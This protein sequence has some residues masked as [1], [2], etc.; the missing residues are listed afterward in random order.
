VGDHKGFAVVVRGY[1]VGEVD[2]IMERIHQATASTDGILRAAV[3]AELTKAELS[4]RLRGY[5][6]V[7]VDDYLRRAVD[8]LA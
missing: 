2:A 5:D 4:V 8:R 3:R 1:D 6:R 7:A